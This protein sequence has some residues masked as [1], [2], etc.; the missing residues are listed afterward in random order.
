MILNS[1]DFQLPSEL[2]AK[3]PLVDR[4]SSRLLTFKRSEN[5]IRDHICQDL[6]DLLG[7]DDVLVFNDTKVMK[8]RFYVQKKTG[9]HIEFLMLRPIH[10]DIWVVLAKPSKRLKVGDQLFIQPDIFF[11]VIQKNGPYVHLQLPGHLTA[12]ELM[13]KYGYTPLP[14]YL[15]HKKNNDYHD[16]YQTPFAEKLGAVAAPTAGRHFS[17]DLIDALKAKGVGIIYLTLHIGYGTFEPLKPSH[18]ETQKLH[19]EQ[20]FISKTSCSLLNE[21]Y[22]EKRLIA[23]GTTVIRALESNF[24]DQRFH[25]GP[26]ETDLFIMPGYSFQCVDAIITNFHLPKSSLFI[27]ISSFLGTDYLHSLYQ[28]AINQ[29]YRFY[30]FGDA[31]FISP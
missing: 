21:A 23:V 5:V 24:K 2:I 6:V 4:K 14:P 15:K 29:K 30:S 13:E 27:L 17:L 12:F 16:L 1:F 18:F 31:M 25:H 28:H 9:A 19:L 22:G 11:T 8:G 3:V 26:F 7:P 20:Y 10:D